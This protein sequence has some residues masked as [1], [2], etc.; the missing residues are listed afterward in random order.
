MG[1]FQE[2]IFYL[3]SYK[4]L[5]QRSSIATQLSL[6]AF[7]QQ[8]SKGPA[9]SSKNATKK[10]P[11]RLQF[12]ARSMYNSWL[13]LGDMSTEEARKQLT[14]LVGKEWPDFKEVLTNTSRIEKVGPP[15]PPPSIA[16]FVPP[17]GQDTTDHPTDLA[18]RDSE[19]ASDA[20][21]DL[22]A[23]AQRI[24][25]LKAAEE[26]SRLIWVPDQHAHNCGRCEK[27]FGALA[28]WRHHCRKCGSCVCD[29]CSP[30][31]APLPQIGLDT[32][33]R[34]CFVCQSDVFVNSRIAKEA[35]SGRM[36]DGTM[37]FVG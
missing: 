13:A 10:V 4:E 28:R 15:T 34:I 18:G 33:V 14:T 19:T 1:D 37:V 6:Y 29:A 27:P 7:F 5:V 26:R 2:A 22:R 3:G 31:R 21:R 11:S 35:E 24:V 16:P 9:T 25:E 32:P 30:F 20:L 17:K 36:D 8:A 12:V 23:N